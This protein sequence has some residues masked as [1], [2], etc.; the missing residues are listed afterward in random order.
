M[1]KPQKLLV[2]QNGPVFMRS[3]NQLIPATCNKMSVARLGKAVAQLSELSAGTK[4]SLLIKQQEDQRCLMIK[5][6]MTL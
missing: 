1:K 5:K 6:A 3:Y 4:R 2:Q